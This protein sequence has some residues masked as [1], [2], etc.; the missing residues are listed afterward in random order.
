MI[1]LTRILALIL[2]PIGISAQQ[3]DI[4]F[5]HLDNVQELQYRSVTDISQDALGFI[6]F[7]SQDGLLRYDGYSVR[8]FKNIPGLGN[9]LSDNNIRALASDSTGNIWIA[10]QGGGLNK[11]IAKEER[12]EVYK[13][14]KND[15]TSISGNAVW[16]VIV[17][18]DN[19]VW[20]GTWANGINKFNPETGKFTRI[21]PD[22]QF[23]VLAIHEDNDGDIWFTSDGL[24]KYSPKTQEITTYKPQEGGMNSTNIRTISSRGNEIW[25]GTDNAGINILNK[26]T[27]TFRYLTHESE[28][29]KSISDNSVYD[30]HI[31]DNNKAWIASNGGL[32]IIDLS[33]G[34]YTHIKNDPSDP[35][36]LSNNQPRIIFQDSNNGIWIGN[37]G[38]KVNKV[39]ESKAFTTY[40]YD[41]N[42]PNSLSHNT[43]RSIFQGKDGKFWVGT[44]GGGIN[45]INYQLNTL[46]RFE[47]NEN[48]SSQ[49][50]SN[51][52]QDNSEN[53]W[54]GTW[55]GGINIFNPNDQSITFLKADPSNPKSI[56]DNRIQIIYKDS[57]GTLW[58]GTEKG[59]ASYNYSDSTWTISPHKQLSG[60][61]IQGK[62]FIEDNK[63]NLYIG[64]WDGLHR[65]SPDRAKIQSYTT[66]DGL[67]GDHVISLYL[68]KDDNLWIG[69]FGG[70]LTQMNLESGK[71]KKYSELD[72]LP[73]NVIFG[74][75]EDVDNNLWLSTNNGLSK[76]NKTT[77]S[78]RNYDA[79]EGLQ[80]NEF[81]WGASF[82]SREGLL[83]FGG[84]NG[85]NIFEPSQIR[86]N[87]TIPPVVI[88]EFNI[89]NKPA[90]IGKDSVIEKSIT[91]LDE[92]NLEYTHN[93]FSFSFASLNY[94]HPEKNQYAYYLE[95]FD[96]DW[97]Y[98]GNKKTATYTNLDPGTYTFRVKASNND[99]IWNEEGKSITITIDPPF[100][101]TWWFYAIIFISLTSAI[102]FFI[103]HREKSLKKDKL[104]LE[105]KIKE[106]QDEVEEQKRAIK[107]Q[108]E[109]EKDR[110]WKDQGLVRM[111]EVLSNSRNDLKE[112]S[113]NVLK[114][115][116][117]HL[118][119]SIA[120]IYLAEE[121]TDFDGIILN[122]IADFGY[123][124][125]SS[126]EVGQGLVGS[127]FM[128]REI[129]YFDNLPDGYIKIESGLGQSNANYL[130]LI[131]LKYEEIIVGVL[132]LASFKPID[133]IKID[134]TEEFAKRLTTTI[135]TFKLSEQT[136]VL[137]EE[138]R[139]KEEELKHRE[140]ELQQNLEELEAIN[141]DRD[142]RSKE[143][144]T[145]IEQLQ[146][147]LIE[148]KN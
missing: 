120:A 61:T 33:N 105:R 26:N 39:L 27:N 14:N 40:R 44:Q 3:K 138:S 1:F 116:V 109:K 34:N 73:N 43:I 59:L 55:G 31:D 51:I 12:F 148:L 106:A 122:Q 137:L 53:Y 5:D 30:I 76:F 83:L 21:N 101:K 58:V 84:V 133:K 89:F 63:G 11:Y 54:I 65:L 15:N 129:K 111:G 95:G 123:P 134:F 67:S 37:E 90:G 97:N 132:E 79:G 102:V 142:R 98:V 60:S 6:W 22:T 75:L 8:V 24:Y 118:D 62:A 16:S 38:A 136:K 2:I 46:E 124:S 18:S 52:Y 107:E 4:K 70:G 50:I 103:K 41:P 113:S 88:S 68:D 87:T 114:N 56:P 135:N 108:R 36:S 121:S 145:R 71:F 146:K 10:T 99:N 23:P 117:Q 47:H 85:L 139:L 104:T 13:N 17:A 66:A 86:N 74:L 144:E 96:E 45:L 147:E 130:L 29:E 25:V 100:W 141:E 9:S 115:L 92:I 119:V 69:T 80:S 91:F 112:M 140:E 128:D 81:Y 125:K 82:K 19:T 127:C 48:L 35:S 131:P 28:N 77:K 32:D 72:G 126:F 20:V 110:I 78:F 57:R 64:T 7:A 94:N 143:L 49:E 42:D 93:V